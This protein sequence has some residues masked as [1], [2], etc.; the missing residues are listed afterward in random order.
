MARARLHRL[1]ERMP[2]SIVSGIKLVPTGL[3]CT[4][5]ENG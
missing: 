5:A 1:I 3:G 2:P 4:G